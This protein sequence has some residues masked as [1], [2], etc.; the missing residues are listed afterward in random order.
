MQTREFK[1]MPP[2]SDEAPYDTRLPEGGGMVLAI[3][4]VL[5]VIV[6]A[7]IVWA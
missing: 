1:S 3:A 5:G 7:V 6:I 2:E 4:I